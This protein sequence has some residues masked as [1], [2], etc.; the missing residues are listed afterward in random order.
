MKR[1][2]LLIALLPLFSVAAPAQVII[3][4]FMADNKHTL[5]DQDGDFSDWIELYNTQ[6]TNVNLANWAL[7]DTASHQSPWHFPATN[8][9]AK[10][11]LVVFA[12]GKNRPVVGTELH[13][14]FSLKASGEYL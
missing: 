13:T 6:S 10:G 3:S 1:F 12:S 14:D 9:T 2:F 7:T 11:F 4:E 8:L 5:A